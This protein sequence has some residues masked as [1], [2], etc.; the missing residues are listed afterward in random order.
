M[1]EDYKKNAE[2]DA[3]DAV[4]EH[5]DDIIDDLESGD[6]EKDPSWLYDH[7]HESWNQAEYSLA[8]AA[9]L[10]D[11]LADHEET[12]EGMWQGQSPRVAISTQASFTYRN[13]CVHE[14]GEIIETVNDYFNGVDGDLPAD[15]R[16]AYP[17]MALPI[18]VWAE[19]FDGEGAD[20]DVAG[21]ARQIAH[22]FH[23]G[24]DITA[25]VVGLLD[26]FEGLGQ[27][28]AEW[29]KAYDEWAAW[30]DEK[31]AELEGVEGDAD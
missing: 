27:P 10:L 3:W 15:W 28:K 6:A 16:E 17:R 31:A 11:Q 18:L 19:R 4:D 22:D 1:A 8:E 2:R 21:M 7:A 20:S 12:D 24:N 9:E 26:H 25:V 29:R 23:L 30:L 5:I 13:A 14:Y